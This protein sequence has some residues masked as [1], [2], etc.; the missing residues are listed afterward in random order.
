MKMIGKTVSHYRI[1]DKLGE[2][3]MGVVYKAE[4]IKL[5]RL[6]ALKFLPQ[7]LTTDPVEKERFVHEAKAAS[8]LNHPNIATIY[9]IDEF[10]GQMFM[11]ME[12][13]EGN[14]LKQTIGKEL[15]PIKEV[16]DIG[17]QI[18]EG[19]N[20]AHEKGIVHRD[21]K[22]SNIMLTS[23]D[24]VKIMDFGLA[25]LKGAKEGTDTRSTLGTA[26]YMSPEQAQ[27]E[28]VDQK[29]DI[30]SCGVVLY[31]LLT[32]RL[33][34]MGEH[35]AAIIYSIINEEPQSVVRF[36]NQVSARLEDMV[37]KALAKDKRE[38]YQHIDDLLADLRREKKSLEYVKTDRLT[39][40]VVTPK[41]KRKLLPFLVPASIVFVIALL[42]LILKP[43]QLIVVPEEKAVAEENT[44]AIMYF[45]NLKDKE[46]KDKIGEM[47][48]ELLITDLSESQYMRVVSS[49]RLFDIFRMMGKKAAK[50][51]DKTVASEVAQKAGA[52]YM[53]LGKILS[54]QPDLIITSQLV[55]VQTGNVTASQRISGPDGANI[56]ALVDNLSDEV[57][58]DLE[59]PTMERKEEEKSVA[60]ITTHSP[61]ALRLYLE[62]YDL[63]RKI[64]MK[65]AAEKFQ[66]AIKID[67]TFASAYL[68]LA[69]C[70]SG[71]HDEVT[72][73][74]Y[75]E[76]A[77]K[78][79]HKVSRKEKFLIDAFHQLFQSK[80]QEA[81][82]ILQ[83][84]V[85]LYPD[86][87][88]AYENLAMVNRLMKNYQEAIAGYNKVIELDSLSKDAYN[89]L[90][91][92]YAAA[93]QYDEAIKSINKYIELAPDEAN[94]Y[95]TRGDI[96]A[97]HAEVDQAI[98]SYNKALEIKPDF[99]ASIEKLGLMYLY[100][101]EYDKAER[102][103][104]RYG[105][106]GGK[107][108]RSLSR[109]DLAL[110]PLSQGKYDLA[111]NRLQQGIT[112]DELEIMQLQELEK[113]Y[114]LAEI[115]IERRE[116]EKALENG[117]KM[118]ELI[119]ETFPENIYYVKAGYGI[120]L[121]LAGQTGSAMKIS[122]E[123]RQEIKD[124]T[125]TEKSQFYLL[126]YLIKYHRGETNQA[127]KGMAELAK[128]ERNDFQIRFWLA[129]IYLEMDMI[130]E[131]VKEF[132]ELANFNILSSV[133]N[134]IFSSK[135]PYF[136]GISYEK[137]G[138]NQ[139]AMEKYE[140][141]LETMKD[142]DPGIPEVQ[143]TKERVDKLKVES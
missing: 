63:F 70:Y 119:K 111:V 27:G 132:E 49:Q 23:R 98:E 8:A 73:R 104:L 80:Y 20:M 130:G 2:G 25:K 37:F 105:E 108:D 50:V 126:E 81:R 5:E 86:E 16:L 64:Y 121:V 17:I 97:H 110:I 114:Y 55:D 74:A 15:L 100:K 103:L 137:S 122:N 89:T 136:L 112:S 124:K 118:I 58:K 34:F 92:T 77:A 65:E 66:E 140:E 3:G 12:Y 102:Y 52:K 48:S 9:E 115:H 142:A 45:E 87:K 113:H 35:Q 139:K 94:P 51:I 85:K 69:F 10:E 43:F 11:A 53:L 127:L 129:K 4:D 7:H 41:P 79:S 71:L 14:T 61:E 134:P 78:F 36:N 106:V 143:D 82:K 29:S 32:G 133:K 131:A 93:G 56:F 39:R 62:G 44:L 128:R 22:S 57:K 47:V 24:Q 54:T 83:E 30:F 40:E 13:V 46:D 6:V 116:F 38:R 96:Y 33:P 1:L 42:L 19:L 72:A 90:A 120:I 26:A 135:I 141:Y 107:G 123:I 75:V 99:E 59:L 95:D 138:W 101:R 31:E 125:E 91:Y 68:K 67:S 117:R 76:K 60:D 21:I 88:L 84:M 28:E 109:L 18:C